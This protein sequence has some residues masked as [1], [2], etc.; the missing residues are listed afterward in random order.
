LQDLIYL[1]ERMIEEFEQLN[2][3]TNCTGMFQ[4]AENRIVISH[5][6]NRKI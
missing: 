6:E 1:A 4:L 2:S 3:A 5:L